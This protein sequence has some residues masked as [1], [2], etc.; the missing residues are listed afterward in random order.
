VVSQE[1]RQGKEAKNHMLSSLIS[2]NDFA[3]SIPNVDD[4]GET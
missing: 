2:P 4:L 1:R 3:N